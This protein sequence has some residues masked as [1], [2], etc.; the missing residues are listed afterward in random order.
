MTPEQITLVQRTFENIKPVSDLAAGLFYTRLFWLQP[1][2]KN[3]FT[4]D[5]A[6]QRRKFIQMLEGLV[7]SLDYPGQFVVIMSKLGEQHASFGLTAENYEVAEDALLWML[8][9][10]LRENYNEEIEAAW[11]EVYQLSVLVMQKASSSL[12]GTVDMSLLKQV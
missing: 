2:L 7:C 1:S 3:L 10:C 11:K 5:P 9:R 4:A 6:A 8:E 12:S